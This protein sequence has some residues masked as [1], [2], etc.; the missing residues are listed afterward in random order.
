MKL[1]RVGRLHD[2]VVYGIR[3]YRIEPKWRVYDN[4]LQYDSIYMHTV[5]R[6][7]WLKIGDLLKSDMDTYVNYY[8]VKLFSINHSKIHIGSTQFFPI[9]AL[10]YN[11][12]VL[13][14]LHILSN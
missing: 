4:V 7:V 9:F 14:N 12:N 5:E 1:H 2:H 13:S 3:Y 8:Y 6:K 11:I 10:Y